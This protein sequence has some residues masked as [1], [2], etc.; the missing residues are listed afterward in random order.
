MAAP[1]TDR[2][3]SWKEIAAYLGRSVR[4]V[5][6]WESSE[7]LPVHRHMH[8]AL[9][10]VYAYKGEIDRWR[11]SGERTQGP[12][13]PT[14][15]RPATVV[16][17]TPRAVVVLP[18][19]NLSP[20]AADDYFGD[21]LTDDVISDLSKIRSLR[22]LSRTSSMALKGVHRDLKAIARELG[23]QYVVQ[24]TVRRAGARFRMTAQLIDAATDDHLWSDTFDGPFEDVFAIEEQLTRTIVSALKLRL[25]TDEDRQVRAR[26]IADVHAYECYLQARREALG[27]RADAIERAIRLLQNGLDIVGDNA[28]LHAAM[29]HAYLQYREAG[30]DFSNYPLDEADKCVHRV[31]ALEPESASGFQLRG[32]SQYS[33]GQVQEAVR[34]LKAAL[35]LEPGNP[36]TLGLLSNCYLISGRVATAR[37]LIE[38]LLAIDPLTPLTRCMPGWADIL[39]GNFAAGLAPY[40]DMFEMDPGN[41]MARLFYVWVL[42]LN[43]RR[44]EVRAVADTFPAQAQDT[45]PAK[46]AGFFSRALRG[47]QKAA[48]ASLTPDVTAAASGTDVFARFLAQGYALAGVPDQAVH[49]LAIAVERGF[50][51]YPFL[52]QHDPMLRSLQSLDSFQQLMRLARERWQRFDE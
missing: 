32:W 39:E 14:S 46:I 47:D 1:P 26:P 20:D 3:D 33:R 6:R 31:F 16:A 21:A 24:G 41:P 23:V 27:W 34:D 44:D 10:S 37:P 35:A 11:Q 48:L 22:V 5:R 40:R 36:D 18:F 17:G 12:P 15:G 43:D 7:G 42:A 28:S 4:T 13:Q 25:S 51:N 30:I 49:W 52:A 50:I 19:T 2:L 45:I 29:G 38:R 8:R 9:G